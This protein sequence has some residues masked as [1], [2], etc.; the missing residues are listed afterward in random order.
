M[1][2][3]DGAAP[4]RSNEITN[5]VPAVECLADRAGAGQMLGREGPKQA[6]VSQSASGKST[7]TKPI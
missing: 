7:K 6:P 4:K 2:H 3:R 5:T 1:C